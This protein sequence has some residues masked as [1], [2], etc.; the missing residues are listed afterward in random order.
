V[1]RR[2]LLIAL[3]AA[4]LG[5]PGPAGAAGT[6][7][8]L[9]G[10]AGA[11]GT[12]LGLPGPAGAFGT[13]E[14]GGQHREHER[15]TRAA[16]ACTARDGACF[17][18]ASIDQ[19]A[20]DG[21]GF[22]AVGSPDRTEASDPAAHC[23]DADFLDGVYPRTRAEATAALTACV[24]H[25][26]GRLGEAVAAAGGLLDG[27]DRIVAAEATLDGD[28]VLD[29]GDE[30]RAKCEAL[31]GFG[32]ALHGVQDFYSHSNWADAADRGRPIAADN[33]PGLNRPAPSPV[34]DLRG[35]GPLD[36][37]GDLTTGCYVL[38]DRVP[39]VEACAQRVTHA[40]LNKDN[41]IID[42]ATGRA[43][44]PTTPRGQVGA[45]FEQAVAGAVTETR[46]QW[47]E[48][49]AALASAYGR[50]PAALMTCALTHDDPAANCAARDRNAAW[51]LVPALLV[52]ALGGGFLL[53]T[54][55]QRSGAVR[56]RRKMRIGR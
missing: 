21:K 30:Q 36:V 56:L 23:D 14:G 52:A 18:P 53:R 48:F 16:L 33:P 50:R 15:I 55:R 26:R 13:V 54:R 43:Q 29:P 46:H 40:G 8:G 19:L 32:R 4:V 31:E 9:P 45:D 12:V 10:P 17:E 41:G 27:D 39:G 5:L 34:L 28:C 20:G 49:Q 35:T 51:L 25:L 2:L 37:P 7:L 1:R 11:A 6:V 38:R 42:P 3:C 44:D 24:D 47:D 22:G